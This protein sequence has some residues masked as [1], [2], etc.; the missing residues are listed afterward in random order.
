M[1]NPQQADLNVQ[2][3]IR[4]SQLC[5]PEWSPTDHLHYLEGEEAWHLPELPSITVVEAWLKFDYV[6]FQAL[7]AK[8]FN[9]TAA[10]MAAGA[11]TRTA[12]D[13]TDKNV[14]TIYVEVPK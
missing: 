1:N 8:G 12:T 9:R 5:H 10:A 14:H 11:P 6:Y 3:L 7:T 13:P 4:Q 2:Q